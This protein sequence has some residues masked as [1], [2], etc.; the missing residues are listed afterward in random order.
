MEIWKTQSACD[1]GIGSMTTRDFFETCLPAT[2]EAHRSAL[3]SE[4]AL[5]DEI[6]KEQASRKVVESGSAPPAIVSASVGEKSVPNPAPEDVQKTGLIPELERLFTNPY[7]NVGEI[8][9]ISGLS[10][11]T[12]Y[13][14]IRQ[15]RLDHFD[16]LAHRVAVAQWLIGRRAR[17]GL[18]EI[19][20]FWL[21]KFEKE[22][23]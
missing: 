13:R 6:L 12:V 5:V 7:L 22:N 1:E 18:T 10:A 15:G 14:E 17:V 20:R 4:A 3:L 21:E 8:V 2:L 11:S 9:I 23:V 16:G 19:G